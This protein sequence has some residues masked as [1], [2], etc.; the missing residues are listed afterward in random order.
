MES[1]GV[2]SSQLRLRQLQLT[3]IRGYIIICLGCN[4]VCLPLSGKWSKKC[5]RQKGDLVR[6]VYVSGHNQTVHCQIR[7]GVRTDDH[8]VSLYS[9]VSLIPKNRQIWPHSCKKMNSLLQGKAVCLGRAPDTITIF[10]DDPDITTC[11]NMPRG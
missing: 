11:F 9:H 7:T 3:R 6:L 8:I 2:N 4:N 10:N 1:I 5:S